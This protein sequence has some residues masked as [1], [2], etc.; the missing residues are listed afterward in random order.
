[1]N[2]GERLL[3]ALGGFYIGYGISLVADAYARAAAREA[4]EKRAVSTSA[5]RAEIARHERAWHQPKGPGETEHEEEEL[6][7]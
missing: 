1:M 5:L 2:A 3:A 4:V 7:G 6:A